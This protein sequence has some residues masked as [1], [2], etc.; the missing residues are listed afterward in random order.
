MSEQRYVL[1]IAIGKNVFIDLAANLAR[2]FLWWHAAS[3]IQ[4]Q[5][6]TDQPELVPAD[7]I[8]KIEVIKVGPGQLGKGFSS[9]LQLDNLISDGKT[10]FIDSDCLIFGPLYPVF[11]KFNGAGVSVIGVYTSAGEWFGDI[12]EV[13]RKFNVLRIPKFNGGLYYLEKG[14]TSKKVYETA[15][16]FEKDYDKIG[17]VRL[18][19]LPNDEVLMALAMQLHD[20][21]PLPDDGTV[22]SDPQACPGKYE[23]D[24]LSGCRSL[25]NPPY[26]S[27]LHQS[28]YPFSNVSP[29]VVHFLGYYTLHYPYRREVYR[30]KKALEK[31]LNRLTELVVLLRIEIPAILKEQI[32]KAFRPLYHKLA[33]VRK[34]KISERI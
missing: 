19:G 33:G 28:W 30:L 4:F 24:V 21:S 2:S 18:R 22:M 7:I 5:L 13:C 32:K 29:L 3:D 12:G 16:Q 25:I 27:P 6:V 14:E 31:K 34:V 26:P 1:T 20:Q 10:L 17:F 11:D 8:N 9:K 15:R 23:I